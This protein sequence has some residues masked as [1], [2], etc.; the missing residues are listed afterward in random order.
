MTRQKAR[1]PAILFFCFMLTAGTCQKQSPANPSLP[2]ESAL[3]LVGAL[4]GDKEHEAAF[5]GFVK[6]ADEEL[7]YPVSGLGWVF[8]ITMIVDEGSHVKLG[9][10]LVQFENEEDT[11]IKADAAR[12]VEGAGLE[13]SS[14][15]SAVEQ[16]IADLVKSIDDMKRQL[17]I[18]KLS[19]ADED[20]SGV[21][22]WTTSAR[23]IV[24]AHMDEKILRTKLALTES[25]LDR[26]R[27]LL[28]ATR[29]S[30][31]KR[32]SLLTAKSKK[33][34]ALMQSGTRTATRAGIVVYKRSP[35]EQK[36]PRLG[37]TVYVGSPVI[38]VY[39]PQSLYIDG[40]VP[41]R[42]YRHVAVGRTV[43]VKTLG[44][45]EAALSGVITDVSGSVMPIRDWELTIPLPKKIGEQRTFKVK[46]KLDQ[47][48]TNLAPDDEVRI[49]FSQPAE[50]K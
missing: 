16:E 19:N 3:S 42:Q 34:D 8:K 46:I 4:S 10:P 47:P 32:L 25:K 9:Q 21:A 24:I 1:G 18:L 49:F 22:K 35:W 26:K 36:K 14:A 2:K 15:I 20:A 6:A 38:G 41:E 44:G 45:R 40:Y 43:T 30:G 50:G 28:S 48:A 31:A 7:V 27:R 13:T 37:G 29:E 23:E 11:K 5:P 39:D 33:L 17:E 12:E